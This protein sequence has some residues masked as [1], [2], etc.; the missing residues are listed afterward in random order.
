MFIAVLF[1][2][3]KTWKQPKCPSTGELMKIM[4][5]LYT[6]E[7]YEAIIKNEIIV[8]AASDT[9]EP[10]DY[11]AKGSMRKAKISYTAYMQNLK[12]R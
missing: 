1:I 3:A 9:E 6:T 12:K 4:W 10:G 11:H 5:Y 8:F 2:I 7:Y